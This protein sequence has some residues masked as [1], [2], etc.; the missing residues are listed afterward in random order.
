[1]HTGAGKLLAAKKKDGTYAVGDPLARA[2]LAKTVGQFGLYSEG[3]ELLLSGAISNQEELRTATTRVWE[4][5]GPSQATELL[6]DSRVKD[7]E[8]RKGLEKIKRGD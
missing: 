6:R 3:V 4:E 5:S 1:V 8:V 7:A 2:T